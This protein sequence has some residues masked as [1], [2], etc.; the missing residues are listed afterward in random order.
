MYEAWQNEPLD[1]DW[2]FDTYYDHLYE[3]EFWEEEDRLEKIKELEERMESGEKVS[4][5]EIEEVLKEEL[6]ELGAD[7]LDSIDEELEKRQARAFAITC[8]VGVGAFSIFAAMYY[9][10]RTCKPTPG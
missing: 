9:M 10:M 5:A 3:D 8:F 4:D 2:D 6:A 1:N 7:D